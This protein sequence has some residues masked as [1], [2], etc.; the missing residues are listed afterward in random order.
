M[1][2][3]FL[4]F[5]L[6][7]PSTFYPVITN[8]PKKQQ[9]CLASVD[10]DQLLSCVIENSRPP[11]NLTW[12]RRFREQEVTQLSNQSSVTH[13]NVTYTTQVSFRWS[14]KLSPILSIFACRAYSVPNDIIQERE[15][16]ILVDRVIDYTTVTSITDKNFEISSY[17][18]LPCSEDGNDTVVWKKWLVEE[19][20]WSAV[21]VSIPSHN[22]SY[23]E[24]YSSN[25]KL[26]IKSSLSFSSVNIGQEG[27]YVCLYNNSLTE[28]LMLYNVTIYGNRTFLIFISIRIINPNIK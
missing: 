26:D 2:N 7:K 14:S 20:S 21:A 1:L 15:S 9:V 16:M 8:C 28:G 27:L 25:I 22:Y 3:L 11:T 4:F 18:T 13:N 5:F 10:Y 19:E 12:I 24:L 6:V 23:T 17:V